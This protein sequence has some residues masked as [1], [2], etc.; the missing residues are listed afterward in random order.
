VRKIF[1][2]AGVQVPNA[3]NTHFPRELF[4]DKEGFLSLTEQTR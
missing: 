1:R 4:P 2:A 3:R